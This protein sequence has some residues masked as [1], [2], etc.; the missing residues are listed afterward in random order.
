VFN[1]FGKSASLDDLIARKK[2]VQA[3]VVMR[4]QF[5]RTSP[6]APARQRFADLLILADR[7]TEAIPIL[8]GLA[9]EH[10]RFGFLEKA[11]EALGRLEQVESGREDVAQRLRRITELE[12]APKPTLL[13]RK[14]RLAAR[15]A[16]S[17][18]KPAVAVVAAVEDVYE[19][20][21]EP[22]APEEWETDLSSP[23]PML[24]EPPPLDRHE[25]GSREDDAIE[26]DPLEGTA[27]VGEQS[28][29]IHVELMDLF[30]M[31]ESGLT[32]GSRAP[33]P[34]RRASSPGR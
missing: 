34:L 16:I 7:Q 10:L 13:D 6:D 9:D 31:S 5:R 33:A 14:S 20:K 19:T 17:E 23:I 22:A 3:L 21:A 4:E 30:S 24:L 28:D 11:K 29:P 32:V 27:E 2:Y 18:P 8:L 1:L 26:V 12:N 15:R 25:A